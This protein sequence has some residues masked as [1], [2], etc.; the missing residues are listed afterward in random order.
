M[1]IDDILALRA[2]YLRRI[3]KS[4]ELGVKKKI[5]L[6]LDGAWIRLAYEYIV[7]KGWQDMRTDRIINNDNVCQCCIMG[8][9]TSERGLFLE[10]S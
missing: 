4:G 3:K 10:H 7:R 5:V 2:L 1:E 9:A 6:H 8:H